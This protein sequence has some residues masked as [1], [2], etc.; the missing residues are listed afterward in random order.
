MR[1]LSDHTSSHV[2]TG[3]ELPGTCFGRCRCQRRGH[4]RLL[5]RWTFLGQAKVYPAGLNFDLASLKV[6]E[7]D[8]ERVTRPR[9]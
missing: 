5:W 9:T 3:D 6:S 4:R 2:S 7:G 8:N 1:D